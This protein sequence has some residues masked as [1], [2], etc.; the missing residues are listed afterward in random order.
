MNNNNEKQLINLAIIRYIMI[1]DF[2]DYW[3]GITLKGKEGSFAK[4]MTDTLVLRTPFPKEPVDTLFIQKYPDKPIKSWV[5]KSHD[6]KFGRNKSDL[7][8]V[9]F[10]ISGLQPVPIPKEYKNHK[11]GWYINK[12][13]HFANEHLQPAFLKEMESTDEWRVFEHYCHYLLKLIGINALHPFSTIHN[14]GKADGEFIF[15]DLYVIYDAT[16]NYD[17]MSSK[18]DQIKKVCQ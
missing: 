12:Q 14:K 18:E 1:T 4:S 9:R 5:G 17:F 6:F 13:H 15:G 7:K 16:L 3:E 10:K 2:E 11:V 8:L